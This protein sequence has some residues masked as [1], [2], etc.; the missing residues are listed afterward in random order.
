MM[1]SIRRLWSDAKF[2]QEVIDYAKDAVEYYNYRNSKQR[3]LTA[4]EEVEK[5][6]LK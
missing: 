1:G 2:Y 3:F 6:R 4:L 5:R